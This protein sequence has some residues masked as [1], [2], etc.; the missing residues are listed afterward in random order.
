[1]HYMHLVRLNKYY[2]LHK[3]P[4]QM[5]MNTMGA[6]VRYMHCGSGSQTCVKY[7]ALLILLISD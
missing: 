1:M 4:Y 5:E 2:I 7:S 6:K 3:Q